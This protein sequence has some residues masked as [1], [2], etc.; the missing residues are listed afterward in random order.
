MRW[1]SLSLHLLL[2]IIN[3]VGDTL[4][5]IDLE[6]DFVFF[7]VCNYGFFVILTMVIMNSNLL[8]KNNIQ[9]HKL[10]KWTAKVLQSLSYLYLPMPDCDPT[11]LTHAQT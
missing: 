6:M 10:Q 5:M 7:T 2:S 3:K 1:T 9:F 4:M 11:M 8:L